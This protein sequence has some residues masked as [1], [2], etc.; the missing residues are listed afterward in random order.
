MRWIWTGQCLPSEIKINIHTQEKGFLDEL[1][2][3]NMNS[4]VV[5][6]ES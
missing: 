5:L 3:D 4:S 1:C 2:N 6:H